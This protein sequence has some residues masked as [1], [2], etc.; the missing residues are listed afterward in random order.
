MISEDLNEY[1]S[2][3]MV[4]FKSLI[5]F[6]SF[7][8]KNGD[9]GPM[10]VYP[11]STFDCVVA[12]PKKG[13]KM[14]GLKSY[15]EYQLTCTVSAYQRHFVRRTLRMSQIPLWLSGHHVEQLNSIDWCECCNKHFGR[16]NQELCLFYRT[17][18]DLSTT[19]IN[20]LTGYT[21]VS[22]SSL[23][24]PFQFHRFQTNKLRVG[25]LN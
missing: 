16:H 2:Y 7:F 11:T 12:D 3:S 10:W 8:F 5:S 23:D 25:I 14:Y 1:F 4:W 15:I 19:D 22:W 13:S 24:Q 17:L 18:I 6:L 20:T 9:Y 21:N